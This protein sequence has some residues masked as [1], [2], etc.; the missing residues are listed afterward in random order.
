MNEEY[1]IRAAAYE[2]VALGDAEI[3]GEEDGEPIFKLTTTGRARAM[4]KIDA[5]IA[6]HGD[7]AGAA[8][9]EAMGVETEVGEQLVYVRLK[10]KLG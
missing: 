1:T 10:E 7:E 3:V 5:A 8:L 4:A 9:A 2:A 6:R